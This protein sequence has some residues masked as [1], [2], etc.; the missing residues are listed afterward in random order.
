[1]VV[2][3]SQE[4]GR[5]PEPNSSDLKLYPAALIGPRA[6]I[7]LTRALYIERPLGNVGENFEP[8]L[9]SNPT[10]AMPIDGSSSRLV[11][12]KLASDATNLEPN[13]KRAISR[14]DST[15]LDRREIKPKCRLSCTTF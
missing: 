3:I 13:L 6:L 10:R 8:I 11:G 14:L 4:A 7:S 1:M 12:P 5:V 2:L 9:D 15:Q